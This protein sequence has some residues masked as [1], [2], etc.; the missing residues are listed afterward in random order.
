M[1][2]IKAYNK[3]KQGTR[4]QLTRI[5]TVEGERI[6]QKVARLLDNNEPITDGAS[7]I[8]TERKDGVMEAYNIRTDRFEVA[9]DAMDTVSKSKLAKREGKGKVV[10]LKTE[11]KG[12]IIEDKSIQ[13]KTE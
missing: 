12:D 10:K 3:A 2:K 11:D 7:E 13:G 6:E 8:F 4:S 9:C 1:S 5:E